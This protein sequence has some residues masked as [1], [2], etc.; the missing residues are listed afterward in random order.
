MTYIAHSENPNGV[1][2]SMMAHSQG[3]ADFMREFGLS[4]SLVD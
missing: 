2:Q 3:V 1:R 4:E